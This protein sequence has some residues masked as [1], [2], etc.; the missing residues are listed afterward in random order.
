MR[1]EQSNF[2]TPPIKE[3]EVV[4]EQQQVHEIEETPSTD[5]I[6][7]IPLTRVK[8]S[9]KVVTMPI[10]NQKVKYLPINDTNWKSVEV[11]SRAGKASGK[12]KH[13][14]NVRHEDDTIE[15][16]DWENNVQEWQ[17]NNVE[18]HQDEDSQE[19]QDETVYFAVNQLDVDP[20]LVHAAK[21]IIY[22]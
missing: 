14:L 5:D 15:A 17:S 8:P 22:F 21:E 6:Q 7:Q 3:Q 20:V 1:Y 2:K 9:S 18:E 12:Y 10:P 19:I 13:W 4:N 16:V 11:I